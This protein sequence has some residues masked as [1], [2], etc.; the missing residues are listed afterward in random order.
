MAHVP[1]ASSAAVIGYGSGMTSHVLLGSRK[2]EEVVTIEIEPEMVQGARVFY[3]AN[4]RAYDDPR[5]HIGD[6]RRQVL[7]RLGAPEVRRHPLGA[8]ESVGERRV[9]PVHDRVLRPRPAVPDGRR[10][11]GPVDPHLRA[12]RRAGVERDG[13]AAR[14]L[15]LLRDLHHLRWRPAGGRLQPG[16]AAPRRTGRCSSRPTCNRISAGSCR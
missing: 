9:R 8:V 11:A 1:T 14:E 2:L 10:R 4:R 13:G 16:A 12:E 6:R 5:S 15:P 3:P 7:L